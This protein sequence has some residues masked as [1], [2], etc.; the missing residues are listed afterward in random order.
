[1]PKKRLSHA[2]RNRAQ[3]N[4]TGTGT[5]SK[6]KWENR[7]KIFSETKKKGNWYLAPGESNTTTKTVWGE[8]GFRREHLKRSSRTSLFGTKKD[9]EVAKRYDSRGRIVS[10]DITGTKTT[11]HGKTK[12]I[13]PKIKTYPV[14]H[15]VRKVVDRL[16]RKK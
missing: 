6:I 8:E 4:A 15:A 2:Q 16:R 11:K 7:A 1:M 9:K 5:P 3:R 12:H 10:T 13:D 14:R